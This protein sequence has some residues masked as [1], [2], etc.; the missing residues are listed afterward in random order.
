MKYYIAYG[1][2]LN[3]EQMSRR[4]PDARPVAKAELT[5]TKLVFRSNARGFGVATVEYKKGGKVPIGIWRISD[6]DEE[7]L[8]RYEGYPI[9]YKKQ[10]VA[11]SIGGIPVNAMIYVMAPGHAVTSPSPAYLSTIAQG[12]SDFGFSCDGLY[13]AARVKG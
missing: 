10:D 6:R 7:A 11:V 12:Y 8:D 5:D 13:K 2:N 9:L 4:C 1:S 3:M